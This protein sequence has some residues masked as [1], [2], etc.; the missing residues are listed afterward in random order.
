MMIC[1]QP[2]GWRRCNP[3]FTSAVP[4]SILDIA[5]ILTQKAN[6]KQAIH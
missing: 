2:T 5:I 3:A 1:W 4:E 6:A